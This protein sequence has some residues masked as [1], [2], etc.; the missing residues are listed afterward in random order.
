MPNGGPADKKR[1]RRYV[2]DDNM[3]YS[4]TDPLASINGITSGI[5]KEKV[6][7]ICKIFSGYRK[8]LLVDTC[9]Y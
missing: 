9:P 1:R 5:K 2:E 4:E 8:K 3:R 7:Y 6:K